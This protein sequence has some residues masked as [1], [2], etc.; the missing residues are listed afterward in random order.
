[1]SAAGP[2][3]KD[4]KVKHQNQVMELVDVTD[5]AASPEP[6]PQGA[7]VMRE[8]REAMYPIR[9][10]YNSDFLQFVERQELTDREYYLVSVNLLPN[11]RSCDVRT[12]REDVSFQYDVLTFESMAEAV[13]LSE[14]AMRPGLGP[15]ALFCVADRSVVLGTVKSEGEG[16]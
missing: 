8:V 16:G 6:G 7:D 14:W 3:T 1:M 11:N 9:S 4:V 5:L 10:F 15:V 2:V 12:G 13:A